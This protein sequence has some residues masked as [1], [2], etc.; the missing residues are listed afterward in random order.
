LRRIPSELFAEYESFSANSC[1]L[2]SA[3]GG[4]LEAWSRD[5]RL[6]FPNSGTVSPES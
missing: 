4:L 5:A 6:L 1:E 3:G 2:T